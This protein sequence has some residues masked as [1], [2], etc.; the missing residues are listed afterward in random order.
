M[1]ITNPPRGRPRSQAVDVTVLRVARE[2]LAERGFAGMSMDMV[3]RRA[4]V[5]KDTL[6]RRWP[7]K[8]SLVASVISA[9]ASEQV[10][11]PE[12]G[13]PLDDLL[14]YLCDIV[15]LNTETEFGPTIAGLVGEVTRNQG[16]SSEFRR[17]WQR[18]REIAGRLLVR[19]LGEDPDPDE[20]GLLL[21]QIVGPIY[22]RILLTGMPID[23]DYLGQVVARAFAG[24]RQFT[25]TNKETTS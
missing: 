22:Y 16:L 7:S 24:H 17:F 6:Y 4:S 12:N 19:V 1:E 9:I 10:P 15:R 13:D 21:D 3:A 14:E 20:L 8:E 23:S 5:G 11:A 2:A 25:A 18:R